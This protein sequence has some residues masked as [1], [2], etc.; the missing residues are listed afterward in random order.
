M[1]YTIVAP[2]S[3]GMSTFVALFP[4]TDPAI[5]HIRLEATVA[6]QVLSGDPLDLAEGVVT[7]FTLS[8]VYAEG[9]DVPDLVFRSFEDVQ[10]DLADLS[11]AIPPTQALYFE[12]LFAGTTEFE[13]LGRA[14]GTPFIYQQVGSDD[15]TVAGT[16]GSDVIEVAGDD[17]LVTGGKGADFIAA[18]GN[19]A[20]V[21]AGR[22]AD[23]VEGSD[24]ADTIKGFRGSDTLFGNGGDDH[25][26]G[27]S[28]ADLISGGDG[29]DTILA[30][31]G[32][33]VLNAG[34]GSNILFGG[35]GRDVMLSTGHSNRLTGG[36]D[37][38][39]FVFLVESSS[40]FAVDER[41][42]S[43]GRHV[44]RDFDVAE[45]VLRFGP[46]LNGTYDLEDITPV[47]WDNAKQNGDNTVLQFEDVKI[48][49]RGVALD[50]L[51][52]ASIFDGAL[53]QGYDDWA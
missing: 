35:N 40:N 17:V 28:G 6:G 27:G 34:S 9:L 46:S 45:D 20:T 48:V 13:S 19:G 47:I 36:R 50:D 15:T 37:A 16:D 25:I 23:Y 22:G 53:G 21:S 24:G 49:L 42:Q 11:T 41:E 18:T 39:M 31:A 52:N 38:D 2:P 5:A 8:A 29:N 44:I 43:T 33:D 32:A 14:S 30:G 7:D 12:G 3:D 4:I 10:I 51:T 26:E 1:N